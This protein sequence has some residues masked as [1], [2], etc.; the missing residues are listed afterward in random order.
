MKR[1]FAQSQ[2][3]P[4]GVILFCKLE[5]TEDNRTGTPNYPQIALPATT[6]VAGRPVVVA[7]VPLLPIVSH[8]T[9]PLLRKV[10]SLRF[11]ASTNKLVIFKLIDGEFK[12]PK[13]MVIDMSGLA[14][15]FKQ[16]LR[17]LKTYW[18][19]LFR[20]EIGTDR[21]HDGEGVSIRLDIWLRVQPLEDTER[22]LKSFFAIHIMLGESTCIHDGIGG[23]NIRLNIRVLRIL[24]KI[25]E[26]G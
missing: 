15:L 6:T 20:N 17:A 1:P 12:L 22:H 11:N 14:A 16:H 10:L 8:G 18:C 21:E 13:D 3:K 26:I 25:P 2:R 24:V 4:I 19:L 5:A 7:A 9:R 23:V